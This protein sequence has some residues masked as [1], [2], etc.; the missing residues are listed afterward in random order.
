MDE[1]QIAPVIQEIK[2]ALD[3]VE[4]DRIETELKK[5]LQYGIVLQEAK[6]AIIKKL[7][8]GGFA[9]PAQGEKDLKDLQGNENN[10]ELHVKCLSSR[11]SVMNTTNGT[12]TMI[13]GL[14][15]DE[16]MI[17]RFVSWD[18]QNLEKG[19]VYDLK[20]VNARTFRGEVE[21]NLGA[22]SEVNEPEESPLEDLDTSKLPRYGKLRSLEMKDVRPGM[23]NV[24]I[25]GKILSVEKRTI[26]TDSGEKEIYDGVISD[27]TKRMRFTSWH[28]FG[29]ETGDVVEISGG[30]VKEWRGIPQLNFDDRAEVVK[31]DEEEFDVLKPPRFMAEDLYEAGATD[32]EVAGTII[33]IKD[34]SGLIFR[35]PE[36]NRALINGNCSIHGQQEGVPDLRAK[37]VLDDG[38][39]AMFAVLNTEITQ[40]IICLTVSECLERFSD[41][42]EDKVTEILNRELLGKDYVLRGNIIRDDFGPTVLP[43]MARQDK[44]EYL[45]EAK[46][47]L[48]DMEG[49]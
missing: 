15:A 14:I 4:E 18:G 25:K 36:C 49:V 44:D 39:G 40:E 46:K 9:Y 1:K 16:T 2:E 27:S 35:C 32:A 33:E 21:V 8:G 29:L 12:K 34:G 6:K 5:Y 38:T 17:R 30:Y 3:D 22:F 43:S 48:E 10:V 37:I 26:R 45:D 23:G 24:M 28:D 13:S 19:K 42:E 41:L 31:S 47:M 7:G 11:E 20:G